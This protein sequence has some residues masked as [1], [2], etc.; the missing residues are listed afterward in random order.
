MNASKLDLDKVQLANVLFDA[1]GQIHVSDFHVTMRFSP[2][3]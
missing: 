2:T 3:S 1:N